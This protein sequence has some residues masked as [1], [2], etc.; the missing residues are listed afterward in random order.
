MANVDWLRNKVIVLV[1]IAVDFVNFKES[2]FEL[3]SQIIFLF[4]QVM[5]IN[6]QNLTSFFHGFFPDMVIL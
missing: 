6:V 5:K 4:A 1:I 2:Y 3:D